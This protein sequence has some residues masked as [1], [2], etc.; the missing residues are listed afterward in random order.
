MSMSSRK[1]TGPQS[2]INITPLVDVLLVLLIIFMVI[3]PIVVV[4]HDVD[5]PKKTETKREQ[6]PPKSQIVVSIDETQQISINKD[7]VDPIN[8]Q[9]RVKELMQGRPDK[10]KIIFFYAAD[11]LLYADVMKV[12]DLCKAADVLRVGIVL[13]KPGGDRAAQAGQAAEIGT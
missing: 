2:D 13:E 8:L 3:T 7:P 12:L 5:V 9:V 10:D 11:N 1:G 4:G 6:K